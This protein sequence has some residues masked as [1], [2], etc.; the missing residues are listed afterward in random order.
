MKLI[1]KFF[2]KIG[3]QIY[4]SYREVHYICFI[5]ASIIFGIY[6]LL[7]IEKSN[8]FDYLNILNT[9]GILSTFLVL[10][11]DKIDFFELTTR[12]K[13]RVKSGNGIEISQG[14]KMTNTF[15]SLLIVEVLLLGLQYILYIFNIELVFFLFLS[16]VYMIVGFILIVGVWHGSEIHK[17]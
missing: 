4:N 10:A 16:I 13:R 17:D 5:L 6:F 1:W 14:D 11:L 8:Q 7:K 12:F 15:F 2:L 9:I 3:K